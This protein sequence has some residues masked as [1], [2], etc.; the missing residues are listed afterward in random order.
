MLVLK[1]LVEVEYGKKV[2][3]N[4]DS[5]LEKKKGDVVLLQG[6]SKETFF[7]DET[8]KRYPTVT[9]KEDSN[10]AIQNWEWLADIFNI[11][12]HAS[13]EEKKQLFDLLKK[14]GKP[15]SVRLYLDTEKTTDL[16]VGKNMTFAGF[17]KYL[18]EKYE[19][20][21]LESKK[22]KAAKEKTKT[23]EVNLAETATKLKTKKKTNL[24]KKV[25]TATRINK[26]AKA[27]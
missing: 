20:I 10:N 27:A 1:R 4:D 13:K 3:Q 6:A 24:I 25:L 21:L 22:E 2:L 12:V 14:I 8:D 19:F 17:E 5:F 9:K 23:A 11:Y 16:Q 26:F 7:L 18:G 15:V